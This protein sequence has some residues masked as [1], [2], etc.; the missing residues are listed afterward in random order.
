MADTK[1]KRNERIS[2]AKKNADNKAWYKEKADAMGMHHNDHL[3]NVNGVSDYKRMKVNYDLYNNILNLKDLDYVCNPF[4][5]N[6]GQMPAR[7]TN[8]DISS[9]KVKAVLG[10][11][12]KRPF[13]YTVIA[14]NKEATTRKEQEEFGRMREYAISQ[15]MM[16]IRQQ[17]EQQYMQE[18]GGGE[19]LSPDQIQEIQEQIAQETE[20]Q[21]PPEV[22][23]YMQ[24]EHQDPAEVMSNQLLQY[25]SKKLLLPK[26]FNDIFKDGLLSAKEIAYVGVLNGE[27]KVWKVNPMRFTRHSSPDVPF[28]EDGDGAS[29]EHRM[30]P[31]EI[32]KNFGDELTNKE[33]DAI[34]ENWNIGGSGGD[35]DDLFYL[36]ERA[37]DYDDTS[38]ISVIHNVWK[39]LRKIGF[40]TYLDENEEVQEDIVDETYEI[41]EEL[42]DIS[43]EWE[44]LNEVYETWTI[45]VADP[46]YVYMRPVPGQF[47]DINDLHACK[48][49]YYGAYYDDTNSR[50]TSLMDRLKNIQYLY[51]IVMYRIELLMASDKGKKIAMNINSIPDSAGIDVKKW[52]YFMESSSIMWYNPDEEGGG[53]SDANTVAKVLDL[54]LASS[55]QQYIELAEFLRVQAGQST[56]VNEN[57]EGQAAPREAVRNVQQNLQ[58]SSNILEPYFSLHSH[59][60]KNIMQALIETAKIA[61]TG[62]DSVKLSYVLDDMSIQTLNVDVGLLEN[63]TLGIFIADSAKAAEIKDTITQLSHAAMQNGKI[64]LSDVISVMRSEGSTESEEILK[65]AEEEEA[66][67]QQQAQMQE[68]EGQKEIAQEMREFEREKHANE[69]EKIV[70]KETERRQT[71]IIKAALLGAS[72]NPDVDE[73]NDGVNDYVELAEKYIDTEL[74]VNAG[75]LNR[76]K[77]EHQKEMDG[78]KAE[79]ENKKIAN[80]SKKTAG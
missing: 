28:I 42:G 24:R 27:P 68:I 63:S 2:T 16:P 11:E 48:L 34:Y 7:M 79:Q 38:S 55:I 62:K 10:M 30:S 5:E 74:K 35:E 70:V 71:E 44:W 69:L 60:K 41:Q 25:F 50:P 13:D 47:K 49:P 80:Q 29:C 23:K 4:G 46:I 78:I 17:I 66:M 56:G 52:Q 61:Y 43:I 65:V 26:V 8:K 39:S 76:D 15:I 6:L 59:V 14:T 72:F 53:Y 51:N 64:N 40:L 75:N 37:N 31:A 12:M 54:S 9:S 21:T 45:K 19:E 3:Y 18:A 57:V 36:D 1:N 32:V 77:F 67:R 58:Q 73:N 20:A 22:R 33:I